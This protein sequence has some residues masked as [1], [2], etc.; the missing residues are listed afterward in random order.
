M[1]TENLDNEDTSSGVD[2]VNPFSPN[3]I[4]L[5][6]PPMNMGDLIDMIQYGW[7][8]FDTNFQREDDL[9]TVKQQSRLIESILLGLRLPAFYF[10]E[11]SKKKWNI[12]DGLQRCSAIRRFCVE[13]SF[14]LSD[15][16]F[17]KDFEGKKYTDFP[18]E[19]KRD[20][21]TLPVT[22]NKLEAGTPDNVKYVLFKRLNTGGVSLMLQEIRNAMFHGRPIDIVRNLAADKDF[23][24]IAGSRIN[25]HRRQREDFISR[26]VAFYTK[27]YKDYKPGL[28]NF[29][30]ESMVFLRDKASDDYVKQMYADFNKAMRYASILLGREAFRKQEGN[31]E[32]LRP[33][34]RAY[35]EVIAATFAKMDESM[36][37]IL[38]GNVLL[39]NMHTMMRKSKTYRDSFSGG[40]GS[41]DTVRTRFSTFEEIISN[42]LKDII[43]Q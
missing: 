42:S 16:E 35:F 31:D 13:E 28:D 39:H 34:N 41:P 26:F 14:V 9:W 11:E 23:M 5:A 33:L 27:P 8:N 36:L 18:F 19:I 29:I 32:K 7:I 12:I 6:T 21:R 24:D 22:I 2:I 15:L 20:I 30:N 25:N 38:K 43:I 40:T 3:D 17:L 4:R 1:K 37:G 10:E